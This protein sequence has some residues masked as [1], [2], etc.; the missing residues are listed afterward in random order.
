MKAPAQ[1]REDTPVDQQTAAAAEQ[2][3]S[4]D[5]K[6]RALSA[7]ARVG[8]LEDRLGRL[9][10]VVQASVRDLPEFG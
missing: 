3:A 10:A 1:R 9:A 8:L 5:W 2:G 4:E 6:G 7:E